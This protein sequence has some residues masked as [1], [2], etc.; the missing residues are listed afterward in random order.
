MAKCYGFILKVNFFFTFGFRRRGFKPIWT[1]KI[2]Y[3]T[4]AFNEDNLQARKALS[5][6]LIQSVV[7]TPW[8]NS[9]NCNMRFVY[10]LADTQDN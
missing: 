7:V 1:I 6:S 4:Q 8:I 10:Q 9:L 2:Q 3:N 5:T